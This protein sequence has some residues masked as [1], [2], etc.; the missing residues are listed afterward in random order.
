MSISISF[1]S[2]ASTSGTRS[3]PDVNLDRLRNL[4]GQLRDALRQLREIGQT[5]RGAFLR[6]PRAVNSAYWKVENEE[7]HRVIQEDLD[8]FDRYLASIG[9]Y[10][11][12]ELS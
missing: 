1:L 4:A 2:R 3:V 11:K 5:P 10:L 12:A 7:V 6:D 8:D 9:R